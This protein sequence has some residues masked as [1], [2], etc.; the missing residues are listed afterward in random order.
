MALFYVYIFVLI[1]YEASAVVNFRITS[2]K[3]NT[4]SSSI[5]YIVNGITVKLCVEECS[6]L[7]GCSAVNYKRLYNLCEL[8]SSQHENRVARPGESCVYIKRSDMHG[9]D[10][11]TGG[12]Q[13]CD[14][15]DTCDNIQCVPK[16]CAAL[17]V[18]NGV[19]RGNMK[20]VGSLVVI[21]CDKLFK[22]ISGK[23][24]TVCQSNGSWTHYPNCTLGKYCL[25][26][27]MQRNK[28]Y[29]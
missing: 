9:E 4:S 5:L 23:T 20:A 10:L 29:L 14:D 6:S 8:H 25:L 18:K 19:I 2:F 13:S 27:C 1:I 11:S 26:R 17:E 7:F 3:T 16:S 22:D 24:H 15:R 28:K 21:A 12:C